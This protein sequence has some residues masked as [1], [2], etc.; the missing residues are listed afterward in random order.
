MYEMVTRTN[1]LK[2]VPVSPVKGSKSGKPAAPP[3]PNHFNPNLFSFEK[4]PNGEQRE[5]LQRM[6]SPGYVT[7]P[8]FEEILKNAY[9]GANG[10]DG[11]TE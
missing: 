4:I 6:L 2:P 3:Q 7:R 1:P 5:L 11:R 10:S 9:I 8:K